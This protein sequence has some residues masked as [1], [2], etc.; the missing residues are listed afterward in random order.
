MSSETTEIIIEESRRAALPPE[1]AQ[2]CDGELLSAFIENQDQAAFAALVQLH[3]PMVYGVCRRIVGSHHDAEDA[4]QAAFLALAREAGSIAR[5]E[6][7]ANW[8]Y[9]VAYRIALR[10][11]A[12]S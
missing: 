7:L 9:R 8:L 12:V 4:F 6:T 2:L 1:L 3:G 5:R 10:A 11:R